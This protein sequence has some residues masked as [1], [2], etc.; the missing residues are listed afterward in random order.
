[1]NSGPKLNAFFKLDLLD[2]VLDQ[3]AARDV[4]KVVLSGVSRS[5]IQILLRSLPDVCELAWRCQSL[6]RDRPFASLISTIA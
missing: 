6:R 1:M 3:L 2:S 5:R 4:S